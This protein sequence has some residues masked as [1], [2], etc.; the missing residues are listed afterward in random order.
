M[1]Q[2]KAKAK[3]Q[4]DLKEVCPSCGSDNFTIASDDP[5]QRYCSD[6]RNIWLP[7]TQDQIKVNKLETTVG[8]MRDEIKESIHVINMYRGQDAITDP[9]TAISIIEENLKRMEAICR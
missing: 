3:L 6:C 4:E 8:K 5:H 1:P 9:N 2:K 7:L